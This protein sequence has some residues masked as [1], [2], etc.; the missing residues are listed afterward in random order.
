MPIARIFRL[1]LSKM[2]V[3]PT[4]AFNFS[5]STVV[6][7]LS[8]LTVPFLIPSTTAGGKAVASTLSPS[9]SAWRGVTPAPTPP[10]PWPMMAS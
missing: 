6:S 5:S 10:S 4:T 1:S 3:T 2:P 8:R 7:G 9:W